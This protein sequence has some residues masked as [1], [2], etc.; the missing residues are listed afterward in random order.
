MRKFIG[1]LFAVMAGAVLATAPGAQAAPVEAAVARPADAQQSW[2]TTF[3]CGSADTWTRCSFSSSDF[4]ETAEWLPGGS[5]SV[6]L[7][8]NNHAAAGEACRIVVNG[9]RFDARYIDPGYNLWTWL[10]NT[11]ADPAVQL[12][13]IRRSQSGDAGIGGYIQFNY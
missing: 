2:R 7:L 9:G 11:G 8:V 5:P 12:E 13:C 10:G 3:Y 1:S 6:H 4:P